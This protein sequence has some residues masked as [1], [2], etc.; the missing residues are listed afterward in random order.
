MIDRYLTSDIEKDLINKMV[1]IGGPRQVGK[2]TIAKLIGDKRYNGNYQYLNWDSSKDRKSIISETF[3]A[4]SK[5]IIFDELHKYKNW[6]NYI[7]GIYDKNKENIKIVVTGSSRLDIFRKGGDSLLGRYHYYRLH[8]FSLAEMA[9]YK[10]DFNILNKE[11]NFK[12]EEENKIYYER[13]WKYGGFPEYYIKQDE[14]ELRRWHNE[15]GDKLIKEDIRD[16]EMIKNISSM[17]LLAD[18]LKEKAASDVSTESLA[19]DLQVS[20]KT[21]SLWLEM[22]ERFY[23]HF[24]IYPFKSNKIRSLRKKAKLYLWDWSEIVDEG[25]RAE[26]IVASHLLKLVHYLY[27]SKG[28]KAQLH[29]LKDKDQRETDFLIAVDNKPWFAVEV[30]SSYKAI[31]TSL[32]YFKEKLNIPFAYLIVNKYEEDLMI[33]NIRVMSIEK[34]L[35][36]LV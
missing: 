15:R 30:K 8:P 5:Y 26:N 3:H 4:E 23:Y 28:Y 29:Y 22:L 9:G 33:K 34:F 18:L 24:R 19:E 12:N 35:T 1:F 6:K 21:V 16:V 27:D 14:V 2:T 10:N 36:G 13:L 32:K 25:K 11:L 7:K 20:F 17:Q 31:P